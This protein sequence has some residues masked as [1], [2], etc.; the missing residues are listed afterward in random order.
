MK[1]SIKKYRLLFVF[2]LIFVGQQIKAQVIT[3][4]NIISNNMVLQQNTQ[5]PVWGWAIEGTIVQITTSWG[6]TLSAVASSKGKWMTSIQTPIAFAG[7][8]PVYTIT[9]SGPANI[10][11]ISNILVGEV[12]LCSGQSN[13]WFPLN[14]GLMVVDAANEVAAA[15]YPSIRLFTVTMADA[16]T[17]ASNCS[18]SW[19]SCTPSTAATFTA[20]GYYFAREIFNNKALNVP[21]GM[22]NDSYYGT[23][24]QAWIKDSVLRSDATLKTKYIDKDYSTANVYSKPSLIYNAMIAPVIP[25]AIKGVLWYQGEANPG[26]GVNYTKANQAMLK[27]WRVDWGRDFSF[28]AVQIAPYLSTGVTKDLEAHRAYFHE[29]QSGIQIESKTEIVPTCDLLINAD[30]RYNIHP[31]NKKDVG[32]R[33]ASLA[34]AKDYSQIMQSTGPVYQSFFVE[35]N[36]IRINYK[37]ESLGSGLQSKDG[38][39]ITSFRIAGSDKLFYPAWAV[40]DGNT[41]VVSSTYVINPVAVRFAFTDAAM[42][43]LINKE[44]FAA[45]PFRTDAWVEWPYPY[46]TPNVDM[47][48]PTTGIINNSQMNP[49]QV[50][51]NPFNDYICISNLHEG[52]KIVNIYDV[53]G[54][55]VRYLTVKDSFDNKLDVSNLEKGTY[56]VGIVQKNHPSVFFKI[57]K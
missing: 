32:I 44:G 52:L 50:Y 26:D 21:V 8:A 1:L 23:S 48:E 42:T 47:A 5:V 55:I 33:L 18:G 12:W 17:P 43:N 27:D 56:I 36:K 41:V 53:A 54:R 16:A 19:A 14:S 9:I 29:A 30:E 25:F 37:P 24:I 2:C 39:Y 51:P 20:V 22:I 6:Q 40:I 31:T 45:Y 57:S 4:P 13:M 15:N 7:Q 46:F 38:K 3:I 10:I 49:V 34:L 35:G 11:T 28:Y